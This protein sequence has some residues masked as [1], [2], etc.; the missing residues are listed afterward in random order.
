MVR[1]TMVVGYWRWNA[2]VWY[3]VIWHDMTWYG[4]VWY[5]KYI[6]RELNVMS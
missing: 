6:L 5:R 4:T 1:Y 3:G 2:V